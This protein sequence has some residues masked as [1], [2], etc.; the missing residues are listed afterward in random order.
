[1]YELLD[2]LFRVQSIM[3]YITII[4]I[5]LLFVIISKNVKHF[6]GV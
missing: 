1:M 2:Y 3:S 5:R 6:D 4:Y